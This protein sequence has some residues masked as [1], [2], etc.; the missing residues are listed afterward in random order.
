M[1]WW[2]KTVLAKQKNWIDLPSHERTSTSR[3][4]GNC[5]AL[6]SVAGGEHYIQRDARSPWLAVTRGLQDKPLN[7]G[8]TL[9]ITLDAINVRARSTLN[10]SYTGRSLRHIR[11]VCVRLCCAYTHKSGNSVRL[12]GRCAVCRVGWN[13]FPF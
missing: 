8:G 3:A 5:G 6:P 7:A 4:C 2:W 1:R 12:C 10:K 9:R 11:C 13:P